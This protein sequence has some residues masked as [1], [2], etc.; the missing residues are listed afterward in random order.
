MDALAYLIFVLVVVILPIATFV[1][2]IYVVR[3]FKGNH[4][5]PKDLGLTFLMRWFRKQPKNKA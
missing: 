3:Y 2:T 1:G 4:I 5:D